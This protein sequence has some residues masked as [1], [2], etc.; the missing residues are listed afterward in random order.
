MN[1]IRFHGAEMDA[2]LDAV[3]TPPEMV[4]QFGICLVAL[5]ARTGAFVDEQMEELFRRSP[6]EVRAEL[7]MDP[8]LAAE[9]ADV[10]AMTDLDLLVLGIRS[11]IGGTFTYAL[12]AGFR[13]GAGLVEPGG[14]VSEGDPN[15]S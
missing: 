3:P 9:G 13:L 14:V 12:G 1:T 10:S 11:V 6:E 4:E 8:E 15:A 2:A 5:D 7:A